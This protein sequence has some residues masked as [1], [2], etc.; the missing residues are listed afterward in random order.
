MKRRD[1]FK[2]TAALAASLGLPAGAI[3]AASSLTG[4]SGVPIQDTATSHGTHRDRSKSCREGHPAAY[5]Q[6][7]HG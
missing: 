3:A 1:F 2:S 4:A 6:L 7:A 5:R